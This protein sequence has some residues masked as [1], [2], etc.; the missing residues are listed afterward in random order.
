MHYKNA[1]IIPLNV[2]FNLI[3]ARLQESV[4]FVN[5]I[6]S[7]ILNHLYSVSSLSSNLILPSETIFEIESIKIKCAA[8]YRVRTFLIP[9][10]CFKI[11][12]TRFKVFV[13]MIT[14]GTGR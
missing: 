5:S 7:F 6:A 11:L 14:G 1:R 3:K 2:F 12:A 8:R 4:T 10:V 13:S 9:Y